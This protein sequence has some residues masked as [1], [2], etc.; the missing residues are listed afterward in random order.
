VAS[1]GLDE[2]VRGGTLLT[3]R[4]VDIGIALRD[5]PN[6]TSVNAGYSRL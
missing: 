4:F 5:Y 3:L 1:I 2:L 6:A